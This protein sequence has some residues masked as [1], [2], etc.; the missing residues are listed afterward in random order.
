MTDTARQH[1]LHNS[2][3]M[4]FRTISR[5]CSLLTDIVGVALSLTVISIVYIYNM[6]NMVVRETYNILDKDT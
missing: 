2:D 6:T 4:V 1:E 3:E 5:F